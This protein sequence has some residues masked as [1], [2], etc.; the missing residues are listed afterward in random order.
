MALRI[1]MS[2]QFL[3]ILRLLVLGP[4]FRP[5]ESSQLKLDLLLLAAEKYILTN[6][7]GVF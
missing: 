2:N 5:L 7:G 4:H 6:P 1:C 3:F